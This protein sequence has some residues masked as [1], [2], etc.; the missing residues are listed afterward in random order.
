MSYPTVT[1]PAAPTTT[2]TNGLAIASLV[3]SILGLSILGVIFGHVALKKITVTGE[4]GRGLA[5]AGLVIGYLGLAAGL[6]L[7]ILVPALSVAGS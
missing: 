7:F 3:T 4:G 5:L 2:S 6:L 1:T